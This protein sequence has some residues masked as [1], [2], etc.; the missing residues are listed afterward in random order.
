MKTITD[1]EFVQF[2]RFIFT[3]HGI[4]MLDAPSGAGAEAV[5][6]FAQTELEPSA[7]HQQSEKSSVKDVTSPDALNNS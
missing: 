2:Q 7:L 4:P 1:L 6:E 5:S 3:M